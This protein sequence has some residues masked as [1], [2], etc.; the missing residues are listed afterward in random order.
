VNQKLPNLYFLLLLVIMPFASFSQVSIKDSC[1]STVLIAPSYAIQGPVGD[2]ANRFGVSSSVGVTV[3]IKNKNNWVF[4]A[5]GMF[6]FGSRITEPNLF[7]NLT[8]D[9]GFIVGSDG[10]YAD[11]RAFE[12]GYYL[13]GSVGRIISFNKPNPNSG[14]FISAGIGFL[15][16][17]IRIEDKKNAVPALDPEYL[18]GYD[19][20]TNGLALKQF[21]GYMY[22]GNRRLVNFYAGIEFIEGFTEGRRGINFD[23]GKSDLGKRF[24]GLAGLRVGWIMPFYKQSPE[25]FYTY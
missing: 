17:K 12:R 22:L 3:S 6:I 10:F 1:I 11:I 24:D 23:T 14:I 7:D 2:M 20:L 13:T 21:V 8:V 18:K 15:Q 16:H 25:K 5:E 9:G 4:S 19:R